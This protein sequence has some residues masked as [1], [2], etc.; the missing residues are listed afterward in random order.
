MIQSALERP[1]SSKYSSF[2]GSHGKKSH[3]CNKAEREPGKGQFVGGVRLP[4][5][6]AQRGLIDEYEFG[7]Q[8]RRVG[9]GRAPYAGLLCSSPQTDYSG[10]TAPRPRTAP[11]P[12]ALPPATSHPDMTSGRPCGPIPP[13][14]DSAG[15][16]RLVPAT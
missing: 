3:G 15:S 2:M 1:L 13:H 5:A 11:R 8:P 9:H 10:A 14:P 4:L 6:L 12:E 7:V 16:R